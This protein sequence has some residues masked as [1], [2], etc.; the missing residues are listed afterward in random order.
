M[1][2]VMDTITNSFLVITYSYYVIKPNN[3]K[4]YNKIF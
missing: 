1:A 2:M 4:S 3:E